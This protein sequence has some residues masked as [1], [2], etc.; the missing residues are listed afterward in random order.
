[1][2]SSLNATL[3]HER[4]PVVFIV[5]TP[6][7]SCQPVRRNVRLG[8]REAQPPSGAIEPPVRT[9]RLPASFPC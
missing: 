1:M 7:V 4:E 2:T 3:H 9:F 6:P 5:R 8:S